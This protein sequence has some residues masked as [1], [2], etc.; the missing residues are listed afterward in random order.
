MRDLPTLSDIAKGVVLFGCMAPLVACEPPGTP[1]VRPH[2]AR[3]IRVWSDPQTGCEYVIV[4]RPT[5]G[6]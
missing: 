3:D 6:A 2:T 1:D 4:D 5:R